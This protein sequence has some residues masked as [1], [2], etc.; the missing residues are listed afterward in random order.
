MGEAYAT[1]RDNDYEVLNIRL[2]LT[3]YQNK[4]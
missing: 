2:A 1:I 3:A 4:R